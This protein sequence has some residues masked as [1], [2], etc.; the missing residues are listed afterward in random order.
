MQ[1]LN[2]VHAVFP[3][4]LNCV[5][6]TIVEKPGL[7]ARFFIFFKAKQNELKNR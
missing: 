7:E 4:V 3:E 1:N 6:R 5:A 2:F